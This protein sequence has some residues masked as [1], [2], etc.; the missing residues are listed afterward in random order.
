MVQQYLNY[1]FVESPAIILSNNPANTLRKSNVILRFYFGN[2]RKLLSA[3]AD[4][5][6]FNY[7]R[8]FNVPIPLAQL[9]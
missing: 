1:L 5:A 6:H 4:V 9:T 8:N 7:V 2:L 3:N